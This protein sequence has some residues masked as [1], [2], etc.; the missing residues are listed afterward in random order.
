MDLQH[1]LWGD[2]ALNRAVGTPH[3]TTE[4]ELGAD[5]AAAYEQHV[6]GATLS[7]WT[8]P[9]GALKWAEKAYLVPEGTYDARI[10]KG[11]PLTGAITGA[12]VATLG[13]QRMSTEALA[14]VSGASTDASRIVSG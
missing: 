4:A 10:A 14:E 9:A 1:M 13:Q 7:T 11:A 8:G 6:K 12:D 3:A 5:G 2:R